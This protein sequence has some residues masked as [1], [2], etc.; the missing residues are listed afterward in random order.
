MKELNDKDFINNKKFTGEENSLLNIL[1]DLGIISYENDNKFKITK[2]GK[3]IYN[4]YKIEEINS[5]NV[6]EVDFK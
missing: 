6:I 2:F 5:N 1:K 3:D 4:Y